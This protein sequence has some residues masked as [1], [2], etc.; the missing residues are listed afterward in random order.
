MTMTAVLEMT[1]SKKEPAK[2]DRFQISALGEFYRDLLKIDSWINA[3]TEANQANSLLCAKLQE[4]TKIIEDRLAYLAEKRGISVREL[5]IQILQDRA[6]EISPD[7]I[8]IDGDST[9][10][11]D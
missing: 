1:Q 5:R 10:T 11:E 3:R 9:G 2:K 6:T 4:R 8:V 7:E